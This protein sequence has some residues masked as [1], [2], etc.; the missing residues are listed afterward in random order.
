MG[1]FKTASVSSKESRLST[2]LITSSSYGACLNVVFG[3]NMISGTIIDY[4]DFTA[5]AHTTTTK[6]GG[7]G[8]SVKSSSTTYTYTVAIALALAEGLGTG[9]GIILNGKN[10][11]DL[12]SERLTFFNGYLGDTAESQSATITITPPSDRAYTLPSNTSKI[13]SI[14]GTYADGST[15]SFESSEY[16]YTYSTRTITFYVTAKYVFSQ[17]I[18]ISYIFTSSSTTYQ[19]PWGYMVTNHPSKALSYSGVCYVAGVIDLGDSSSLPNYTFEYYGLCQNQQSTPTTTKILQCA[20]TKTVDIA[21]YNK[22]ASDSSGYIEEYIYG[23]GWVTLNDRYYTITQQEDSYGNKIANAYEYT[24]NFDDR[25]DGYDRN[26]PDFIRIH[27]IATTASVTY[28]ATDANPKDI[29]YNLLVNTTWGMQFPSESIYS[30]DDYGTYC[31]DNGLLLSPYY[32]SQQTGA[33]ILSDLMKATNSEIVW[34]QGYIKCIPYYDD[35]D[36]VYDI[37]DDNLLFNDEESITI[38]RNS[39]SDVYNIVPV[40]YVDRA[41]D[42]NTNVVYATDE[43]DIDYRGIRQMSTQ[44]HHEITNSTAAT[45]VA[46]NILKRQL[47]IL[48]QYTVYLGQEFVLLEPMDPVTLACSVRS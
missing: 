7:K 11:T 28:T 38:E 19:Y 6:S 2:F 47:Y 12:S 10:T 25:T 42:Y 32:G 36:P 48:N 17:Y 34:S 18:T 9:I 22:S 26:D 46:N 1:I 30:L 8:G 29:V 24:F 5:I 21:N 33:T 43:G 14:T 40:E 35:L 45:T 39:Q 27:Y 13:L 23:S 20:Y 4:D 3:T 31:S 41:N 15:V 16:S 37:S 44:T